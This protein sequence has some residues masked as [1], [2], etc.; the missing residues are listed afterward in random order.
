MLRW[1]WLDDRV[2][3]LNKLFTNGHTGFGWSVRAA[4]F[5]I[6]GCC[7]IG[8][9]LVRTRLPPFKKRPA[10]LQKKPDFKAIMHDAPYLLAILGC[11]CV[12]LGIFLPFFCTC[13]GLDKSDP[14]TL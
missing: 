11:F 7:I 6:M 4:A 2:Q 14:L 10:H 12:G 5:L 13:R 1:T 9:L 3:M 8:N